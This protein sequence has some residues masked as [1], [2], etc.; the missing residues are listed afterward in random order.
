MHDK[1]SAHHAIFS[2]GALVC[3]ITTCTL[4]SSVAP[5]SLEGLATSSPNLAP[6]HP[7]VTK[8]DPPTTHTLP[9]RWLV[10]QIT[11]TRC[12]QGSRSNWLDVLI[13]SRCG[14]HATVI[15]FKVD[16]HLTN[17]STGLCSPWRHD[18]W[19]SAPKTSFC[20]FFP[21]QPLA[22]LILGAKQSFCQS[23]Q[24]PGPLFC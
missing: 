24:K 12:V 19:P 6:T 9:I 5:S 17:C 14:W 13:M 4:V 3:S 20:H 8:S 1:I 10:W 18:R 2:V 23:R 11:L 16:P 7:S 21:A 22:G 15:T